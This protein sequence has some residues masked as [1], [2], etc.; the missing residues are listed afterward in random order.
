MIRVVF[1][2]SSSCLSTNYLSGSKL[3]N[4]IRDATGIEI[5]EKAKISDEVES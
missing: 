3:D 1:L 2:R 4:Q 5:K